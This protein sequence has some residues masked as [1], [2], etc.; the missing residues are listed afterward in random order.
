M[1][2]FVLLF[3]GQAHASARTNMGRNA[4]FIWLQNGRIISK[5]GKQGIVFFSLTFFF[6]SLI[7]VDNVWLLSLKDLIDYKI[8][9]LVTIF[10]TGRA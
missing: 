10:Y 5:N 1:S 7:S 8:V 4:T 3:F 6:E 2:S 9:S